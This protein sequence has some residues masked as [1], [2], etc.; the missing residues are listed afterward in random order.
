MKIRLK[1]LIPFVISILSYNEA[2]SQ[3]GAMRVSNDFQINDEESSLPLIYLFR[4]V[5]YDYKYDEENR[6]IC[7]ITKHEI[8]RVTNDE[9]LESANKIYISTYQ[10]VD[11][12]ELDAKAIKSNGEVLTLDKSNIKE[13]EDKESGGGYRIFAVEGAEVN[14]VIDYKYTKRVYATT[15]INEKIQFDSKVKKFNFKLS[16]PENLVFEFDVVNDSTS[17]IQTDPLEDK[18]IYQLSMYNIEGFVDEAFSGS[19]ANVKRIDFR[20]SYNANSTKARLNTFADAGQKI[21]ESAISFTKAEEKAY[22]NYLKSLKKLTPNIIASLKYVE[23][24]IKTH[25]YTEDYAEDDLAEMLQNGFGHK[26]TFLKLFVRILKDLNI[27]YKLVV[28]SDRF[29]SKF[30]PNFESW[31]YL[32]DFLIYLPQEKTFFAPHSELFRYG[33]VPPENTACYGLFIKPELITDFIFPIT[34]MGYITEENYEADLSNLDMSVKFNDELTSLLFDL[35]QISVNNAGNY[36][37]S[38]SIWMNEERKD[39]SMINLV[40]YI[41]PDASGI[42]YKVNDPSPTAESWNTPFILSST[43]S[44]ENYIQQAGN[45]LLVNI[46][47]FIGRQSEM[48]QEKK[49][50]FPVENRNNRGYFRK[51]DFQIPQGYTCNNLDDI[52]M[53]QFVGNERHPKYLFKS[54]YIIDGNRIIISIEEFY[55][56]I[57]YP[58]NEFNDFRKV[59]NAAAD[60]NKVVLVLDKL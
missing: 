26:R 57:Y 24:E 42:D 15:F 45:S 47:E 2:H 34:R 44:S 54:E 6:F 19:T 39:E 4:E 37:K 46:G 31:N 17:V 9:A 14:G 35:S 13:V 59:V 21:Y 3:D 18:N 29:K 40:K 33:N 50:V 28:T 52:N 27:T 25:F 8:I 36:Y 58:L 60:W 55:N 56:E 43:F 53:L 20:L 16:C 23:H 48:Y 32:D 51:I 22:A 12:L 5:S 7:D 1:Y 38:I 11:L 10:M 41:A 30:N 49:R